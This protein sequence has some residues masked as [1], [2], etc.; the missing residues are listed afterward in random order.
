MAGIADFLKS[1]FAQLEPRAALGSPPTVL[2]GVPDGN[3]G[4]SPIRLLQSLNINSVFDLALSSAFANASRLLAAAQSPTN[5]LAEY[6]VVPTGMVTAKAQG[7]DVM[8]L[9][10][11]PVSV[12][13]AVDDA[14]AS[15]GLG[16]MLG[17]D[18]VRDMALWPPYLAAKQ[19][20]NMVLN[21]P[22]QQSVSDPEAPADLIPKSGEY[23]TERVFYSTLVFDSLSGSDPNNPPKDLITA[24][25]IDPAGAMDMTYG[26]TV[27]AEGAMLTYQQS[28]YAQGVALGQL[29]HSVAL[30][31]GEVTKIAMID[32][33]RRTAG[34]RTESGSET[35]QLVNDMT[36]ARSISEVTS[37]VATEAQSGFSKTTTTSSSDQ[38]GLSLGGGDF[39][40]SFGDSSSSGTATSMSSSRGRRTMDATMNQNIMDTTHQAAN[41]VRNRRATVVQEVSEAETATAT[42]RVVTNYNHMHALSVQYYEVVQIYRVELLL[43]RVDKLLF[44]P[45]KMV[46]FSEVTLNPQQRAAIS[47]GATDLSVAQAYSNVA[48]A[49][50]VHVQA[51]PPPVV[52]APNGAPSGAVQTV[53][54]VVPGLGVVERPPVSPPPVVN[55]GSSSSSS[56]SWGNASAAGPLHLAPSPWAVAQASAIQPALGNQAQAVDQQTLSLPRDLSISGITVIGSHD[57]DAIVITSPDGTVTQCPITSSVAQLNQAVGLANVQTISLV[58]K[59]A[60]DAGAVAVFQIQ[61]PAGTKSLINVPLQTG[62]PAE[63]TMVIVQISDPSAGA[64]TALAAQQLQLNRLYYNQVLWRNLDA[65]T[66]ALLLT[67]YSY[68]GQPILEQIDPTPVAILANYLVFRMPVTPDFGYKNSDGNA[69]PSNAAQE[70]AKWLDDHG[71]SQAGPTDQIVPLPS[72]GVF[73]EAVLGRFNSAE[74][75][76]LTRFWNWQDSPIP[77]TP[78]DISPVS[79]ESR[80]N[81]PNLQPGAF[82]QPLVNIVSPTSLPD[83]TGLAAVINAIQNG[84]MFRDM[85]GLAA[86]IGMLQSTVQGTTQ[87]AG[88]A[89][90]QAGQNMANTQQFIEAMGQLALQAYGMSTGATVPS[91]P[92]T[93]NISNAGAALN[94]GMKLDSQRPTT[95]A[96]SPPGSSGSGSAG[97]SGSSSSGT[98]GVSGP[99]GGGS[100]SSPVGQPAPDYTNAAFTSGVLGAPRTP[101]V[102]DYSPPVIAPYAGGS[103]ANKAEVGASGQIVDGLDFSP[104]MDGY[105]A[106]HWDQVLGTGI[107][108][109]PLP[110]RGPVKLVI[111][112][113]S[114]GSNSDSGFVA[115]MQAAFSAGAAAGIPFTVGA[116]HW[117]DPKLTAFEQLGAYTKQF[118]QFWGQP[119]V[120]MLPP[121]IDIEPHPGSTIAADLEA[122]GFSLPQF[123][124][125]IARWIKA[126]EERYG[127]RAIIYTAPSIW[128]DDMGNP[129]QWN[130]HPLWISSLP[131]NLAA[132]PQV[133]TAWSDWDIWQ[134]TATEYANSFVTGI[135]SSGD[136]VPAPVDLDLYNGSAEDLRAGVL[137]CPRLFRPVTA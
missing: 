31:P 45:L 108:S 85:S 134:Y 9:A 17:I 8:S 91:G 83:P 4:T 128:A 12:L 39:G 64:D 77:M 40:V 84:N 53:G 30:A 6:G 92:A 35:E 71:L 125:N 93:R 130:D 57:G 118:D 122:A 22:G 11:Q 27:P 132:G 10:G 98:A 37:A 66:I 136:P 19:L 111:L 58:T 137:H 52:N 123:I 131:K 48:I 112:E 21:A 80:D 104:D 119:G 75:L 100:Q 81:A 120:N 15:G 76:D 3:N 55:P 25:P 127:Y 56:A 61:M 96:S 89:A 41:A 109:S 44:I 82:G 50:K 79:T 99:I 113:A 101:S 46:D 34:T 67:P 117:F 97:T 16:T 47:Q 42:T 18:T 87:A 115:M 60:L 69:A 90:Q 114:R 29:L 33:F 23:P 63:Q 86:T 124:D 121:I 74:K 78:S 88:Q 133:P 54:G 2:L 28:W 26:F 51:S 5:V 106:V 24:G 73:G 72:G 110:G 62:G 95:G 20:L 126:V 129:T 43:R 49:G 102:A 70:W 94:Q 13:K 36:H 116:Y 65:A 59:T 103:T 135:V 1:G 14:G 32:W 105:G 107:S 68:K 38:S 7:S